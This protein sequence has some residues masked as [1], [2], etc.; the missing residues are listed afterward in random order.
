MALWQ[1]IFFTALIGSLGVYGIIVTRRLGHTIARLTKVEEALLVKS[2][3][4]DCATT[5]AARPEPD[6]PSNEGR[7]GYLT[8]RDLKAR[9][10]QL[11]ASRSNSQNSFA[12]P[13]SRDPKET[14]S[15]PL[16]LRAMRRMRSD[17]VPS[18]VN[19]D[20]VET[21]GETLGLPPMRPVSGDAVVASSENRDV[22]E[23]SIEPLSLLAMRPADD[24]A[25][26]ASLESRDALEI[27]SGRESPSDEHACDED[28]LEKKNQD[29]LMFLNNQRRRRR[30]R[31]GY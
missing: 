14:S 24:D 25:A 12:V 5:P 1:F 16:I 21:S 9:S 27:S 29:V 6:A 23:T 10:E 18:P 13:E 8:I 11:R 17:V 22:I 7:A 20:V 30:A 15:E 31:L 2:A 3:P 26:V 19:R 28:W 4:V